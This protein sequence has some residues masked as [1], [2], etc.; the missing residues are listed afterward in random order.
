M[1]VFSEIR[2]QAWKYSAIA[3]AVLAVAVF[4]AA[5]I[6]RGSAIRAG[7]ERDAAHAER[8][9]AR[10]EVVSLIAVIESERA[11]SQA[12]ANIATQYEKE[13]ADAQAVA[14]R[15]IADLRAGN[16]RLRKLWT[17]PPPI[18]TSGEP[19]ASGEPDGEAELRE[20]GAADLVRLAA[21]ADAQIRGLQAVVRA[22]RE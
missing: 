22:D 16:L 4:I 11:K 3:L 13:K 19:A 21:E 5:I 14:V 2:A 7:S 10:A 9:Q 17:C 1:I 18:A 6:F 20:Q 8:D 15:T 12:L